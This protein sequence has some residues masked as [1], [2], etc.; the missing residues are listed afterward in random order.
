MCGYGSKYSW[1]LSLSHSL[2]SMYLNSTEPWQRL[3]ITRCGS[4]MKAL[5]FNP[6]KRRLSRVQWSAIIDASVPEHTEYWILCTHA[7]TPHSSVTCVILW[8]QLS[9]RISVGRA[10]LVPIGP[11]RSLDRLIII[12]PRWNSWWQ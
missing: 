7:C 5:F 1:P 8:F 10:L 2:E 12:C 9:Y 4:D 3:L 6:R 11:K